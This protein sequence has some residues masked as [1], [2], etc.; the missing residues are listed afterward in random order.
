MSKMTKEINRISMAVISISGKLVFYTLVAA[1]LFLGARKG[2]AFGYSVF[3]APGME[4]A[5]GRDVTVEID[6]KESISEVGAILEK[7]GLIRDSAAFSLQAKCY[8]YEV[9]KGSFRLN[10]SQT[11]KDII[12]ILNEETEKEKE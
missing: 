8:D 2:Y 6:G 1:L 11:S 7:D 9:K 3:Y 4:E 5:P 10:T 12:N